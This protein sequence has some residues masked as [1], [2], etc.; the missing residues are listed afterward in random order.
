MDCFT[1]STFLCPTAVRVEEQTAESFQSENIWSTPACNEEV[2][3]NEEEEPP[4]L[5][6]FHQTKSIIFLQERGTILSVKVY[7]TAPTQYVFCF[8]FL[9][10]H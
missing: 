4:N 2:E 10:A 9:F 7:C 6:T 3:R 5:E 1:L 8:V